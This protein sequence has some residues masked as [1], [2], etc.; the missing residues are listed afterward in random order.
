MEHIHDDDGCF[1]DYLQ[2]L[3]DEGYVLREPIRDDYG[4]YF[5][6]EGE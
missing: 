1:T 5:K 6:P 4:F 3:H 2:S